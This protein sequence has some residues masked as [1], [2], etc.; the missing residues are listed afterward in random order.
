MRNPGIVP[1]LACLYTVNTD[2]FRYCATSFGVMISGIIS[3]WNLDALIKGTAVFSEEDSLF[4]QFR[5]SLHLLR[6]MPVL[7]SSTSYMYR[8]Y[9]LKRTYIIKIFT[10]K[11][12]L[13][14]TKLL[15]CLSIKNKFLDFIV[16]R[17]VV[18]IDDRAVGRLGCIMPLYTENCFGRLR[19][20]VCR[21]Q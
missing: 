9:F 7:F 4:L 3:P 8:L 13:I 20:P 6:V 2:I 10:I 16:L 21:Q 12:A 19:V 5:M 15:H 18:W 17:K 11:T 14:Y 1:C